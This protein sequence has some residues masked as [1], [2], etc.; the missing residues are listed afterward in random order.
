MREWWKSSL[1]CKVVTQNQLLS[2]TQ[3]KTAPSAIIESI[4]IL[5]HLF[6]FALDS[7]LCS[8]SRSDLIRRACEPYTPSNVQFTE[9]SRNFLLQHESYQAGVVQNMGCARRPL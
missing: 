5:L 3:V 8:S 1:S 6:V 2:D 4:K 9:N 7:G